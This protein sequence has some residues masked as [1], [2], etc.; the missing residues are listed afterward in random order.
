MKRPEEYRALGIAT[1][2]S[3]QIDLAT[4]PR[5]SRFNGTFGEGVAA[6][7]LCKRAKDHAWNNTIR[8]VIRLFVTPLMLIFW[9]LVMPGWWKLLVGVLFLF[10]YSFFYD[11]LNLTARD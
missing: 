3:P 11:W 2:L 8:F 4:E 1:A 7:V 6:E 9:L 10:S 5:W